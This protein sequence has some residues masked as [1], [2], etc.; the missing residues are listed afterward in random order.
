MQEKVKKTLRR[1]EDFKRTYKKGESRANRL[2]VL[3]KVENDLPY[4]RIGY[5]I[6]KKVGKSVTRNLIRRRLKEIFRNSGDRVKIGYDLIIVVR[7]N[8]KNATFEELESAFYHLVKVLKL[9]N[10]SDTKKG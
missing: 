6:S 7:V 9:K 8:A 10:N 4:N 2:L 1:Q 5:S 3:Y